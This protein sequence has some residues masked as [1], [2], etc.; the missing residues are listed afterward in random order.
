MKTD[1]RQKSWPKSIACIF[2]YHA[3]LTSLWLCSKALPQKAIPHRGLRKE[4]L[5]T[6]CRSWA[7]S[8][9]AFCLSRALTLI[10]C[11]FF[12]R[13]PERTMP[14]LFLS[15]SVLFRVMAKTCWMSDPMWVSKALLSNWPTWGST[16]SR[17]W[18]LAIPC[19]WNRSKSSDGPSKTAWP[20]NW[21]DSPVAKG[22][23]ENVYENIM[24]L[25]M[26]KGG[27][28]GL[29]RVPS[30][31]AA[32]SWVHCNSYRNPRYNFRTFRAETILDRQA[33][34]QGS[35]DLASIIWGH[36]YQTQHLWIAYFGEA[37]Y[38]L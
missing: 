30:A 12:L 28:G 26:S 7:F 5:C 22:I 6:C 8:C 19:T 3:W 16:D 36:L 23:F 37:G 11:S 4:V 33:L 34:E 24:E 17:P 2:I 14:G 31:K 10:S 29:L 15:E 18:R 20:S 38:M 13:L 25:S 1:A 27:G 35:P 9:C 32:L 21:R